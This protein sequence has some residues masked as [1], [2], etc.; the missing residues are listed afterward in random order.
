VADPGRPVDGPA[1]EPVDVVDEQGR[2]V[3]RVPRHEMRSRGLPHLATF[4]VQLVIDGIDGASVAELAGPD[5]EAEVEDRYRSF[6][7]SDETTLWF[8]SDLPGLAS[9]EALVGAETPIVVHRRANW[10]DVNPG[11]WDLAFGGV[12]G[13]G[14]RWLPS[15]RRELE[16]EAGLVDVP[17]IAVGAGRFRDHQGTVLGGLFVTPTTTEPSPNDGEVVAID[18]VDMGRLEA[19][20][21]GRSVCGD[22]MVLVLTLVR[23][24]LQ[25][26]G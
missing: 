26:R 23:R 7:W 25:S 10:K 6:T 20:C 22:S 19:W 4:V 11:F 18:Q 13:A 9:L 2:V 12:L 15:A 5:Y 14:E 16:E 3:D 24:L 17:V 8:G 1:N 21:R